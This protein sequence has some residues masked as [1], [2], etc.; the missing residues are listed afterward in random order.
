MKNGKGVDKKESLGE[1]SD[2][3]V[4]FHIKARNY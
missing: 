2:S 4:V 3:M 1:V